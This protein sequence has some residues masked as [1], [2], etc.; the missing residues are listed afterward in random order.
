MASRL[1]LLFTKPAVAGRVKTR[2]IGSL[3]AEQAAQLHGAFVEDLLLRLDG[4]H[5]ELRVAWALDDD[6]PMPVSAGP[7]DV[8]QVGSG[9]GERLFNALSNAAAEAPLIA[10]I[11]SDHPELTGGVLEE[12]FSV[13]DSGSA[14]IV[15]GPARDGGYYLIALSARALNAELFRDIPWSTSE[16]LAVTLERSRELGLESHQLAVASDVDTPDDLARLTARLARGELR[17]PRTAAVL[18]G[19]GRLVAEEPR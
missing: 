19:W 9:L 15:L 11:G 5:F 6:E 18:K 7:G 13:L 16:V 10:A 8:R 1:V 17:S 3:T 14:D 12:A 4:G 2:L